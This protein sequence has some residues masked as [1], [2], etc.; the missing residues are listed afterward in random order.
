MRDG[1]AD[2]LKPSAVYDSY[3]KFAAERQAVAA[4]CERERIGVQLRKAWIVFEL[5]Q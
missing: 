3:W 4:V 2:R 5:W 1:T